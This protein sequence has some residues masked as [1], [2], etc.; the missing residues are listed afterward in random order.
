MPYR[1]LSAMLVVFVAAT[2]HADVIF[3]KGHNKG[4]D[5]TVKSENAKGVTFTFQVKKATEVFPAADVLDI[6]YDDVKDFNV[7][8]GP[9]KVAKKADEDS[10]DGGLNKR[11][12]SISTAITNYKETLKKMEPHKY[13]QRTIRYRI[14]I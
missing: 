13:A 11:K 10:Q 3:V 9:Y 14:A 5:G 12:V 2:A 6:H 4:I 1:L 8:T 7:R